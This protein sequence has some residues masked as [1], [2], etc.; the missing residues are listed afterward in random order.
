[1]PEAPAV[2][3][4]IRIDAGK[5]VKCDLCD[6]MCPGDVIYKDEANRDALPSIRYPDECWY[7]GLCQSICPADAITI[8]FPAAMTRCETDVVTLLGKP[9][10]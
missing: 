2:H 9:S 5:C 7:C 1:M 8:V 6:W 4:P 3:N 10:S